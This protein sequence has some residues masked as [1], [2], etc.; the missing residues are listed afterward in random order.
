MYKTKMYKH[1]SNGLCIR[2]KNCNFA[3]RIDELKNKNIPY[4]PQ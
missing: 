1:Y 3:H 4:N 2:T